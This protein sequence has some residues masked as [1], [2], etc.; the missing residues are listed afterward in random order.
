MYNGV[1]WSRLGWTGI[2]WGRRGRLGEGGGGGGVEWDRVSPPGALLEP[3]LQLPR[4]LPEGW[5][6]AWTA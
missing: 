2:D 4:L 3:S 6:V 1:D 5:R